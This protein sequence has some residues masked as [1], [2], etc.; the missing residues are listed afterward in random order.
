[1]YQYQTIPRTQY[2]KHGTIIHPGMHFEYFENFIY[3]LM[4]GLS[5]FIISLLM[6]IGTK[7]EKNNIPSQIKHIIGLYIVKIFII[8]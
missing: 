3:F 1:M 8:L 2:K 6:I 5:N 4:F 7:H